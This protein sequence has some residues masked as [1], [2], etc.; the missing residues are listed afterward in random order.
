MNVRY[1]SREE[2]INEL[3]KLQMMYDTLKESHLKNITERMQ[4]EQ[5]LSHS[6]ELMRYVIEHSQSAIA[7]HDRDMKYI[8]VSQ[9]YLQDYKVKDKDIIGKHHYD[10]FPDLPQK[11]RD[12]H[13]KALSGVISSADNDTY[14]RDD[15]TMEWTRWECRPWYEAD[16]TIGGIIVYTEVITDRKKEEEALR[17]NEEMMVSSQSV[18]HICSYSTD[19]NEKELGK[20][21]WV[22]SP[23]FYKIF[24]ID[25]TYPHTIEGWA[26]FIHPDHR[27]KVVAYHEYVIKNRIPF[28][29][30]YKIIRIN[31]GAERWVQG[32]GELVYDEHS[33][34]VRMYG[35]IQDITERKQAEESLQEA[36]SLLTKSAKIAHLGYWDL[37]LKKNRLIWSDETYRIFGL[38]PQEFPSTYEAFLNFV[39]PEDRML[40][41]EAYSGSLREGLDSYQIEHRV[42]RHSTGEIRFVLEKC[43]HIRDSSGKII[44]SLGMVQDITERKQYEIVIQ[45]KSEEIELNNQRLES[46]L[47]ISQYQT[48][49]IQE[50]LDFALNEAIILN[51][52]KIGYIYFYNETNKQ[53]ILN[54]WSKDVMKECTVMNPQTVY[55][56]DK[57]GCWGEA[58]RQRKP[59]VL[60]DYKA[61]NP[62]KRGTPEGHVQLSKFLTIPVIFDDKI[63]A[64]AGVANKEND[65][66]NSDVRQLSLLMDSVWK[67]SER[68]LLIKDLTVSKEKAEESDRLKSAFLANMSHEIRTPMNGIL[69]FTEL[70]KEP[71]LTFEEQQDFIQTIQNSGERML[72]TINSIVDISKIESGLMSV[73]I[74]ETDLNEK[75]EFTYKFFKPEIEKKGLK[76][77]YK[78]GLPS[79]EAVV[80]TDNEKIYGILTNL[81]KNALKFTYVGSIEFGYVLKSDSSVVDRSPNAELE[82]FVKDT[83]VGIPASQKDLIFERFRQGSESNNR[84]YEG[85]GLGLSISRSY[86]EMLGGRIWV[87]SR[88]GEGTTFYFTIPYKP[89]SEEKY[90]IE[91]ADFAEN[92]E[93]QI[94]RMKILIVEDDEIS[95]S[96]LKRLIQKFSSEVLHAVTGVEA[97][98]ACRNN[99]DLDLVLM[100]IRMPV[101]NGLEATQQ[102][103]QFNKNVIIIAQTAFG[104]SS[105]REM[106][107]EAGCNDY[108][109]KPV[110]KDKLFEIIKKHSGKFT[111][112]IQ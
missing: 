86:V 39:H 73:D 76:F 89:V 51:N 50:L 16:G 23:E 52:S 107:L 97:V 62:H 88:E 59:I 109:S 43:E 11:W 91:N 72:N 22:C 92:K 4:S 82:F 55:D 106:A 105:D 10:I 37:D 56:L 83:G 35:A 1:K 104:F 60:N 101:M 41:N 65:Y 100:D 14:M 58:V 32:T 64:V 61:E 70:L 29:H 99:P 68:I 34:P 81:I 18:A 108:I 63:V 77:L 7:I 53:F 36:M 67:I 2:L 30:E 84:G 9:R 6:H 110:N 20:S 94:T 5:A 112:V 98:E 27:E 28:S 12:V 46:L 47:K 111:R 54:T 69:G 102:I 79:N 17:R 13:Q 75:I 26:G 48:G 42:I 25:K 95:Y 44:R 21:V 78:N 103:R 24:G 15:G 80:K 8:Y 45:K 38:K 49:S 93:V 90:T 40:V 87:E 96:L 66:D 71:H 19:L 33:K 31:D 3:Q 74:K 57:T 85:S